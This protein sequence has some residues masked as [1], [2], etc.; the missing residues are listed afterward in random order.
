M[1]GVAGIYERNGQIVSR[2]VLLS[3]ATA[4]AHRGPDGTGLYLDERFGMVNTRLSIVDLA[5]GDQPIPNETGRY[6]VM[7][8]GEIYNAPE[9]RL[10]LEARG[11]FFQT[12]CDTE[13]LVHAY[14]E[15]GVACLARLNGPFA[16]AIWDHATK[17]LFL[18]RDRFGIRP[19]FIAQHQGALIFGSEAK[20]LLCYPNLSP[21]ID[22]LCVSETFTLWASA[23]DRSAF[24]GIRELAPGHFL[25]AGPEGIREER[26]WWHLEFAPPA[27]WR[28]ES[29]DTLAEELRALLEDATRLRLR[30]DVPVA[31]YLSGGLD[32]SATAAIA[33]RLTRHNLAAY[34]VSFADADFDESPFQQRMAHALG[35]RLETV[36]VEGHEI[37][38]VFPE[39]IRLAEKPLLRTAPAPLLLLSRR[40]REHGIKV[41]LTGEGADEV[42]AGYN[43]F[44]ENKVRR[45]WAR[46][47]ESQTRPRLLQ[48]LYPY[49]RHELGRT[50]AFAKAFFGQNLSDT[51]DALYS[52]ALR[53][54]DTAARCLLYVAPEFHERA[55]ALG[56]PLARLRARLPQNFSRSTPLGQAQ[57]LEIMTFMQG[58][59]LHAQGDR[60]LMGN[61]VEG[62]F[63]FLDHR[64][65]EFATRLPDHVRLHGLREKYILRKSVSNLLPPEI[66][67]REKRPYR[68]PILRAFIGPKAPAY[69]EELLSSA[70]LY[71]AGI[72]HPVAVEHLR[73]KC[74]KRLATGI[75]ETDEMA[76]VGILSTMLLHEN[77]VKNPQRPV[78]ATASKV[79]VGTQLETTRSRHAAH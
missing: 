38:E 4:L 1:C 22:P 29:V 49:L 16:F 68:A 45:F 74:E 41:V 76:L 73:K 25:R 15:W 27:D 48:K 69:V 50:G 75:S 47:P 65:A 21:V 56:D 17:E 5:G 63:P 34:A 52:H 60:M 19:L 59:L 10:E 77:F 61:S 78:P 53:F 64:L 11:H 66:A 7:Q 57:L 37:A 58:Y 71:E 54:K 55:A 72:F 42:F 43:I 28:T 79:A 32:S 14:E 36:Y 12:H 13:T 40:V 20:A 33:R 62:R 26:A 46:A 6:W 18:A 70:R 3:M 39:V 8:N 24:L 23:P 51:K 30:A 67:A 2:R 9:L 44:R 31:A 35:T